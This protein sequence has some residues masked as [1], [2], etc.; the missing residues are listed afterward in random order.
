MLLVL[1]VT[2]LAELKRQA[3][4]TGHAFDEAAVTKV[5][6]AARELDKIPAV[7]LHKQSKAINAIKAAQSAQLELLAAASRETNTNASSLYQAADLEAHKCTELQATRL[8]ELIKLALLATTNT[9][10]IV[11]EI[12]EFVDLLISASTGGSTGTCLATSSGDPTPTNAQTRLQCPERLT[13]DI[14]AGGYKDSEA[15]TS[16]EFNQLN[17]Q[18]AKQ[19]SGSAGTK[20]HLLKTTGSS[21]VDQ[22]WQ[23]ETPGAIP[24]MAGFIEVTPHSTAAQ[25]DIQI[26]K[27]NQIGQNWQASDDNKRP[28]K[29]FNKLKGLIEADDSNCGESKDE[30]IKYALDSM[31]AVSAVKA[32]RK[33]AKL[34]EKGSKEDYGTA[35]LLEEVSGKTTGQ[36]ESILNKLK[37][38]PLAKAL[39]EKTE[40]K[41]LKEVGGGD[42][43]RASLF[44]QYI[45]RASRLAELEQELSTE[46]QK[47]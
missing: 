36:E 34:Y 44:L 14:L 6:K 12:N 13:D 30:V 39:A 33:S 28:A 31:K 47:S 25:T 20:C 17:N 11:G 26:P 32:I 41:T 40:E 9:A 27:L 42:D 37:T 16:T 24:I 29:V 8:E 35:K 45:Q 3:D 2:A 10:K 4:S 15:L 5:C 7:D 43:L 1:A 18:A 21:A 46:K 38:I 22:I 19:T 23:R